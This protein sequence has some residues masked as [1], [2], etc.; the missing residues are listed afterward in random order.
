MSRRR[1]VSS[2][3]YDGME[4]NRI[5]GQRVPTLIC[6]ITET[7]NVHKSLSLRRPY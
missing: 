3:K 4:W 5:R 1:S 7:S 6:W 2:R